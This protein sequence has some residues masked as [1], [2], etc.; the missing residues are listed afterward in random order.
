[1]EQVEIRNAS[2]H[3][4]AS[5]ADLSTQLGYPSS[6]RQAAD[7]LGVTLRSSEHLVLVACFPDGVVVGWVHVFL[8]LRVE[9]DSFAEVGGFVVSEQYRG[10]G[11]GRALLVAA[12]DWVRRRGI[13]KLRVRSHST[14]REAHAFYEQL[15]FSM[16]KEQHVFDKSWKSWMN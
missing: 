11:I 12:E 15:G 2:I 1:M 4:A 10:R 7:R 6:F 13:V 8:A 9:S 5:L 16:T 3:D 14:R